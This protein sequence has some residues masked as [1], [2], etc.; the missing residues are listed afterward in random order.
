MAEDLDSY[1]SALAPAWPVVSVAAFIVSIS[2]YA[3]IHALVP[4]GTSSLVG[5]I[6]F[7]LSCG[8]VAFQVIIN[9]RRKSAK[10]IDRKPIKLLSLVAF[11]SILDFGI[12]AFIS[13]PFY[14]L[15]PAR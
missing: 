8:T 13:V 14:F 3:I 10:F 1:N 4:R 15:G 5:N 7:A 6:G 11:P 12:I 2:V 9:L